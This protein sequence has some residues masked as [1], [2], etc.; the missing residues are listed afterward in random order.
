[1]ILAW[2]AVSSS[3][4]IVT[5]A[6]RLASTAVVI[7]ALAVILAWRAVSSLVNAVTL[8][9]SLDCNAV[10]ALVRVVTFA[11]IASW[12]EVPSNLTVAASMIPTLKLEA[13]TGDN[14][15]LDL[16]SLVSLSLNVVAD[17]S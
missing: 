11:E 16:G 8:V 9:V 2:R 12:T 14:D 10:S 15:V 4:I 13:V 7:V 6:T 3:F 17:S 5:L 1:M